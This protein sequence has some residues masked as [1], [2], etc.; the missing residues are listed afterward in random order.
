MKSIEG[1]WQGLY[2]S[3]LGQ[4]V[5]L[6]FYFHFQGVELVQDQGAGI[7]MSTQSLVL[8]KVDL[9]IFIWEKDLYAATKKAKD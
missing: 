9:Q 4:D 7:V 5:F 8:Q 6:C 3:D 2:L 1:F